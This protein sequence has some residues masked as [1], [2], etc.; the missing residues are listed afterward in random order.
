[1]ASDK[2][3]KTLKN[4]TVTADFMGDKNNVASQGYEAM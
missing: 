3:N 4:K 2:K 1:M